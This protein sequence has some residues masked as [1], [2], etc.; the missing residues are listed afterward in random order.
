MDIK[1]LSEA[2]I[3][4]LIQAEL[5][6]VPSDLFRFVV[7][8]GN[9]NDTNDDDDDNNKENK[10]LLLQ[11]RIEDLPGWGSKSVKN[12]VQEAKRIATE[13]ISLQRYIFS[14][15]IRHVGK[16]TSKVLASTYGTVD[17][18]LKAIDTCS[19]LQQEQQSLVS[20]AA[21]EGEELASDADDNNN[22]D[23]I[24]YFPEL[25]GTEDTEGVKDIGPVTISSLVA[26]SQEDALVRSA[27]E[28]AQAILVHDVKD[29]LSTTISPPGY[30][31]SLSLPLQGMTIVFTGS[32]PDMKREEAQEL[33]KRMG[34]KSTPGSISKSTDIL[35]AGDKVGPKKIEKATTLGIRILSPTEFLDMVNEVS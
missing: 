7:A 2:R 24:I 1:G 11:E 9:D 35:V 10:T 5:L 26:F 23:K 13:G 17:N 19:I 31:D 4:Q 3:E 22:T 20:V 29:A 8:S 18:F 6:R 33:A 15:G 14:L 28:L 34:A 25:T 16:N 21:K 12:L 30:N 27:K 32:F